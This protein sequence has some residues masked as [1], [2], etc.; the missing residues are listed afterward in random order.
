MSSSTLAAGLRHLRRKLAAQQR[1][2]DSD[3]QL[4]HAF[5]TRRDD[6]AFAALMRRHGPMVLHVCRRVLGHE[7]DAEDALQATFL[8][9]AQNAA[10]LRNKS[11]LAS[12]L[13]GTA[14]RTAMKAKQSAARRRK[15]EGSLG[16]RTQPRSPANPADELSWREIRALLDEAI[17][18]LPEKY[19]VVFVGFYL[20]DLSREE[21]ARRLELTDAAVAKRLTEA[22]KRL[23]QRLARRGVELTAVLSAMA[24][25][26]QSASALPAGLMATTI[27][28]A[29]ATAAGEGFSGLAPAS[30]AELAQSA[31]T[32]LMASKAK[33]VVI[34]LLTATLLAGAGVWTWHTNAIPQ[35]DEHLA[36]LPATPSRSAQD[37]KA[38]TPQK[39]PKDSI[40]V[41][42]HVLDPDGKP[43]KGARLYWPH[44][45]KTEPKS[46][47][48]LEFLQRTQ[49]GADGRF[50]FE[51]PRSDILPDWYFVLVAVADGYGVDA[52]ELPKD[53]SA[54]NVTLR[55]VK[56]Q[57][58]E[59]RIVSTEGKP[60]AGVRVRVL[61]ISAMRQGRLDDFL[62]A[63][64]QDWGFTFGRFS[65]HWFLLPE[66]RS[67]PALTDKEGRFRIAGA[68]AE[69]LVGLRL[70]GP[71]IAHQSLQIVTRAGFD[72]AAVNKTALDRAHVEFGNSRPPLLYGPTFTYVASAGRR[73]EGTVREV[74]SGKPVAGYVI[75][76]TASACRGVVSDKDGR[77]LLEGAPKRKEYLLNVEPPAGS[78]WLPAGAR[79]VDEEGLRPLRVDFT[80][81]RGIV[82][83]GRVLDRTT[84]RG[85]RGEVHFVLLPGNKFASKHGFNRHRYGIMGTKTEADGR[86]QLAVIPG[87]GVLMF[88]AYAG[89]KANGGPELNPYKQAEFDAED[90]E[91]V[92]LTERG[93]DERYFTAIDRSIQFLNSQNAVKYIDLAPEAGTAKCDLFVD[94]GATQT[95]NIEDADGK[96]LRGTMA[97]GVTARYPTD[98]TI[99]DASCTIF[100]LDPKK[101]RKLYFFHAQRQLAASLTVRGD[102]KGPLA[103]RLFPVGTVSGRLLNREGQPIIGAFVDLHTLEG[104]YGSARELYR[105]LQQRRPPIRTDKDGRFRLEGIVPD[106]QFMLSI[107]QGRTFFVGEP[108]I[109][110][111]Q[112]KPGETLDLGDVRVKPAR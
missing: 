5:L 104:T 97:S 25:A 81:A 46:E 15:R 76:C 18:C 90:R 101:P 58:I 3:E 55:L 111:R 4:L 31:T 72:A 12:W 8:V 110:A 57:P 29:L 48:D 99:Q 82:V 89:E 6:S 66:Q 62:T 38:Q 93:N 61:A 34:L 13:H 41:T 60:L 107:Y 71:G 65:R 83:R 92:P 7:Q 105:L 19:R 67:S 80:V 54:A 22:R 36:A 59:G 49:T 102:E 40:T 103:V 43:V 112:V 9:L 63:W 11:S 91:R 1:S 27:K 64:Q 106:V 77:Y 44:V 20:E 84:G 42:G 53:G 100:A 98:C 10:S 70:S 23:G 68:G 109:G 78:S 94:R 69:R 30:V 88:Q 87:P 24:L 47:E 28:A 108:S 21:T 74:G 39:E 37:R 86:F 85:V 32:T 79:S 50:R 73:I 95:I 26:Q 16:A 17:A 56:D 2:S 45:P 35:S 96:P 14:Y 33:F 52:V 75:Y 51:L